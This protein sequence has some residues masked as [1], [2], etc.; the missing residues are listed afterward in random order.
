VG[1]KRLS[2]FLHDTEGCVVYVMIMERN[3]ASGWYQCDNKRI[4][5]GK[6]GEFG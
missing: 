3:T 4:S 1:R 6:T 5:K 2:V